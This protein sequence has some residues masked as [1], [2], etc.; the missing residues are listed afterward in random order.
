MG[1]H[2][3]RIDAYIANAA[4]FA[5]PVLTHLRT[6][7][8]QAC[9]EVEETVKWG[10][11]FYL[12][13]GMLCHMAAF[14]AHCAFRIHHPD[15]LSIA[16]KEDADGMGQFGK[17][18]AIKD[19]PGDAELIGYIREAAQRNAS[20]PTGT[21]PKAKPRAPADLTVP[22]DLKQGLKANKAAATTFESLTE[23]QRKAYVVWING[24]KQEATRQKRLQASLTLLAE[25]K[26]QD[27]QLRKV[28]PAR[29]A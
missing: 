22:D 13:H 20:Q 18:A 14:K 24:A 6:L 4:P 10:M 21:A 25:G 7:V 9:P 3:P 27:G 28:R 16:D 26:T 5:Q 2:D 23:A 19:L 17:I 15:G 1:S 12:H 11:P 29:K 8:H